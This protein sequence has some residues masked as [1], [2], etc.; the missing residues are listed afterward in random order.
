MSEEANLH[1]CTRDVQNLPRPRPL[2]LFR[3]SFTHHST[4]AC[5]P[6]PKQPSQSASARARHAQPPPSTPPPPLPAAAAAR[7]RAT[8]SSLRLRQWMWIPT[9]TAAAAAVALA[10]LALLQMRAHRGGGTRREERRLRRGKLQLP[11]RPLTRAA[12]P[13]LPPPRQSV[14]PST[15]THSATT[16]VSLLLCCPLLPYPPPRPKCARAQ[17]KGGRSRTLRGR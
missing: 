13:T 2:L 17:R 14:T 9:R 1:S 16:L 15:P 11:M 12:K 8:K 6:P 5:Q 7:A 3:S 10:P 4:S